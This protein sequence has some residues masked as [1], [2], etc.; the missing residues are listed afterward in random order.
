LSELAA[1]GRAAILVPLPTAADDHQRRNAEAFARIGGAVVLDERGLTGERLAAEVLA[2]A[3]DPVRR[4]EM[5]RRSR[6]LARPDAAERIAD[7]VWALAR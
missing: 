4:L 7:K 2:L 3:Q 6:T 5:G 1:A